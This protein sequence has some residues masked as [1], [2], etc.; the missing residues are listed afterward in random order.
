MLQ[1]TAHVRA[2]RPR[3][4]DLRHDAQERPL[5]DDFRQL[6]VCGAHAGPD[7][8]GHPFVGVGAV[9]EGLAEGEGSEALVEGLAFGDGQVFC[10]VC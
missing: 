6:G 8:V 2:L 3:L 4:I 7:V 1:Q 9:G 10:Y 5:P